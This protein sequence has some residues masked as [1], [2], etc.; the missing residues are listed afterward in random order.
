V[1]T[2]D[3]ESGGVTEFKFTL[4]KGAERGSWTEGRGDSEKKRCLH[5]E[6]E[7]TKLPLCADGEAR[8]LPFNRE[9]EVRSSFL[10]TRG[11]ARGSHVQAARPG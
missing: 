9:N 11:K 3:V 1:E 10:G 5:G 7:G 8:S 6:R 2:E 4:E